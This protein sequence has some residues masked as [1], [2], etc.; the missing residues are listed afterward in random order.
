MPIHYRIPG[1]KLPIQPVDDFL[2]LV[3]GYTITRLNE[4][5]FKLE[6]YRNTLIIPKYP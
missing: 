5:L 1:L 6:D 3:K 4:S 2:K